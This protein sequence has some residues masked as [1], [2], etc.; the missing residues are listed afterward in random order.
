MLVLRFNDPTLPIKFN[1]HAAVNCGWNIWL[2]NMCG[3][4]CL[5]HIEHVHD[6]CMFFPLFYLFRLVYI[7][8]LF[9]MWVLVF[10]QYQLTQLTL[11]PHIFAVS[12]PGQHCHSFVTNPFSKPMPCHCQFESKKQTPPI[13]I[14]NYLFMKIHLKMPSAKG[15]L[16]CSGGISWIF[17]NHTDYIRWYQTKSAFSV[18]LYHLY[19]V[20]INN[21]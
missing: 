10:S 20:Y 19:H 17:L 5:Q 6:I 3:S 1:F 8:V 15:W 11:L 2:Y 21:H 4:H 12:E 16:F 13:K 14:Q 9:V 18:V 7:S